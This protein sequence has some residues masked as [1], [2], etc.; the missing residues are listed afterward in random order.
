MEPGINWAL[1]V[2]FFY[3][4]PPKAKSYLRH[5]NRV[6]MSQNEHTNTQFLPST[7]DHTKHCSKISSI[8]EV[9]Y[10]ELFLH[11][12]NPYKFSVGHHNLPSFL[13]K[14]LYAGKTIIINVRD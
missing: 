11:R 2:N 13:V 6:Q 4:A 3:G 5:C 9:T 12:D 8:N 10:G 14:M 7:K 1:S